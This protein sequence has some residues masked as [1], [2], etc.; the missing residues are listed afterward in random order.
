MTKPLIECPDPDTEIDLGDI[1]S[2]KY[3]LYQ[4]NAPQAYDYSDTIHIHE[5]KGIRLILLPSDDFKINYQ[6]GRYASGM[7]VAVDVTGK[8]AFL[9]MAL[10]KLR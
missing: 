5:Y 1:S 2:F 10:D 4:T 9:Q 6:L 3:K 7:H 8:K